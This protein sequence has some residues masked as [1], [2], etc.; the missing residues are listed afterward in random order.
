[1]GSRTGERSGLHPAWRALAHRRAQAV[2]AVLITALLAA[3]A[4]F[5][6]VYER[7]VADTAVTRAFAPGTAGSTWSLT[8][9][10]NS[11][12]ET[13]LPAGTDRHF[14]A[15]SASRNAAITWTG[16]TAPEPGDG[17]LFHRDGFCGQ[18][19]VV[20]GRCP[21]AA[22]EV[23]VSSV[24]VD[25]WGFRVGGT[26]TEA[27]LSRQGS[28][29]RVVGVYDVRDRRA[30]YW[31]GLLPTGHSGWRDLEIPV[32]DY[33][34]TVP[35]TFAAGAPDPSG[36]SSDTGEREWTG[37]LDLAADPAAVDAG[38]LPALRADTARLRDRVAQSP[39]TSV[40]S[41]LEDTLDELDESRR[42]ADA[43]LL[44][45]LAQIGAL[46]L[47]ILA[48][49]VALWVGGRR[50]EL[51][52]GRLRGRPVRRLARDGTGH[53]SLLVLAGTLVGTLLGYAAALVARAR[54]LPTE[55][56]P[57]MSWLVAGSVL[58]TA[59]L[60]VGLGW[61]RLRAA[62]AE[63]VPDLLRATPARAGAGGSLV[64]DVVLLTVAGCALLVALGS[65]GG[66]LALLTP[67][68]LAIAVALLVAHLLRRA[69]ARAGRR[70]LP[71]RTAGTLA[72]IQVA[73]D[74][75]LRSLLVVL[76]LAVSFSIFGTQL[77]ASGDSNRNHR[78]EVETGA[79]AVGSTRTG[80]ASMMAA[81][82][83]IDPERRLVTPV[84]GTGTADD[85]LGL[86]LVEP[87]PFARIGYGARR[88][89][90]A[91]QWG[92]I[93]APSVPPAELTGR[94]ARVEV[95][96]RLTGEGRVD[97]WL[98]YVDADSRGH[99]ALL[100]TLPTDGRAHTTTVRAPVRC[101]E[102]CRLVRWEIAPNGSAR[103]EIT[104]R[105]ADP[106]RVAD[107]RPVLQEQAGYRLDLSA[108][109][110]GAM[111]MR[112]TAGGW[113]LAAQHA[114][115][116]VTLPALL[117]ERTPSGQDPAEDAQVSLPSG[118]V[119]QLRFVGRLG[120]ATPRELEGVALAD[121]ADVTR[122]GTDRQSSDTSVQLWFS[123]AGAR[124]LDTLLPELRR[125][126]LPVTLEGTAA[127]A[128][129]SYAMTPEALAGRVT[130][131]AG[132][133]AAVLALLGLALSVAS[134][135]RTRSHDLAALEVVGVPR[136]A[137]RRATLGAQL[138]VVAVAVVA[139]T[140]CGLVGY[141]LAV[142]KVPLYAVPEPAIHSDFAISW[143]LAVLV[144]AALAVILLAT[145]AGTAR[146]LLRRARPGLI[147]E[148]TR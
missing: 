70:W 43:T 36:A 134:R 140:A 139:G 94:T 96:S 122:S 27:S 76:C 128:R 148:A 58:G 85:A 51:G 89:A 28:R 17:T 12:D 145:A 83:R 100:R 10:G 50:H 19:V 143:P 26:I 68:L 136:A 30:P 118:D 56:V 131:A 108:A 73:R 25:A 132:V 62:A 115:I 9:P 91:R 65:S 142:G 77:A 21:E 20:R 107:W 112:F 88:A 3:V 126:G 39:D 80:L 4:T 5:T 55:P 117:A 92:R 59:V 54:W 15:P 95:T 2:L 66:V 113:E 71:R 116:P 6:P 79:A 37:R 18:V 45:V 84:V 120:D 47:A 104:V 99:T 32:A 97:L 141:R 75:V 11:V 93:A 125:A 69:A 109:P 110:G 102:T 90:T 31:F 82:D 63:P 40:L 98:D 67:S 29:F 101:T 24:D 129:S 1:M 137:L 57:Q 144:V 135:W 33:F 114:S 44:L 138:V 48:M 78:A 46:G 49:L 35:A 22:D 130:P 119:G 124:R 41:T 8:R 146:W 16:G 64:L 127:G 111:T 86:M 61:A 103:G 123:A 60:A 133:L 87:E 53:W 34:L 121:L 7:M 81:L 23:M 42:S 105:P 147:R 38:S 106:L 74:P 13:L 52:L 14:T 72:A